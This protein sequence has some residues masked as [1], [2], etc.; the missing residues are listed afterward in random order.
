MS[1]FVLPVRK[2]GLGN[3][4]FQ[5]AAA[6]V[7]AEET[8]RNILIPLEQSQIHN[9][10]IEYADTIFK[11]FP[12]IDR[13]V[14]GTA[15]EQLKAAG[16]SIHPGEPGFEPWSIENLQGNILLHG[17]FQYY[18]PIGKHEELIRKTF[19]SGLSS[20]LNK[21]W[22]GIH[23]RRGDFLKPPFSD[24]HYV[25]TETYYRAALE[26]FKD[27]E[28]EFKIFSD[29]LEWCKSQ[30]FFQDLEKKEFVEETNEIRALS[31]MASCS[32]GFICANSTFSWWGAFLGAYKYRSPICVPNEWMRGFD[33]RELFPRE[34]IHI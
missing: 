27:K 29:D 18:P 34:W 20:T 12:R 32:G 16:F 22:V 4:L 7:Y 33:T 13:V 14:D 15:I 3:Q 17:Y 21:S 19:L 24:V 6:I 10:G 26:K 2:G 11:D 9:T 23:V 31:L 25:Q 5:V 8:Q 28:I 30:L 1:E